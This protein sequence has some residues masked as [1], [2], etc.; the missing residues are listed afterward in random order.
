MASGSELSDPDLLR[1]RNKRDLF[2]QEWRLILR[3]GHHSLHLIARTAKAM[4]RTGGTMTSIAALGVGVPPSV[5][6]PMNDTIV[7]LRAKHEAI[8]LLKC[9]K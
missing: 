3:R 9:F 1:L 8:L 6:L 5:G 7:A 4:R 2:K